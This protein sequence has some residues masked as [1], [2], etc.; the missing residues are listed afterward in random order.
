MQNAEI[1]GTIINKLEIRMQ[2]AEI[3]FNNL[4]ALYVI[5]DMIF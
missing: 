3:G 1:Y 5:R 2:D 4:G